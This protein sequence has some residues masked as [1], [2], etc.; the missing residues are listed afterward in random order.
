MT[1]KALAIAIAPFI[2]ILL[3]LCYDDIK[4]RLILRALAVSSNK[5]GKEGA[6]LIADAIKINSTLTSLGLYKNEIGSNCAIAIAKEL[7][8]NSSLQI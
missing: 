7:K 4:I 1:F 6:I 8:I 3:P 2:P 5:I